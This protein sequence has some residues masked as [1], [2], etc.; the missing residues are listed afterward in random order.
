MTDKV[1]RGKATK[2]FTFEMDLK[3]FLHDEVGAGDVVCNFGY[4]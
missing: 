2:L 3:K 1:T 4:R